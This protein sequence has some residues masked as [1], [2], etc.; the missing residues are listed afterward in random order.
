MGATRCR[1]SVILPP[2][3]S[4]TARSMSEPEIVSKHTDSFRVVA[5]TGGNVQTA[6]ANTRLSVP[7]RV[8]V[9]NPYNGQPDVGAN[10]TFS[11]GCNKKWLSKTSFSSR[12]N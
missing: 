12:T 10:V 7:I 11:D 6:T 1:R 5:V 3:L 8:N 2:Q 4:P 9:T